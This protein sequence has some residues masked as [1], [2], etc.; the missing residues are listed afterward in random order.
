MGRG[1]RRWAEQSE[2]CEHLARSLRQRLLLDYSTLLQWTGVEWW[3]AL[4]RS[5][6]LVRSGGTK[7][8]RASERK[9]TKLSCYS[10]IVQYNVQHASAS[11]AKVRNGVTVTLH[12]SRTRGTATRAELLASR[13]PSSSRLVAAGPATRHPRVPPAAAECRRSIS[14]E[15]LE[16]RSTRVSR[17]RG[18]GANWNALRERLEDWTGKDR[19]AGGVVKSSRRPTRVAMARTSDR[20]PAVDNG[21]SCHE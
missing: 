4:H 17:R 12:G 7:H 5:R 16:A 14:T 13:S 15:A 8:W 19:T 2:K 20:E 11:G 21:G 3:R 9:T 10:C 6:L 18:G 1:G